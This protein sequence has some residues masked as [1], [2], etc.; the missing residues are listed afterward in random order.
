MD[1]KMLRAGVVK[2]IGDIESYPDRKQM[3]H[4]RDFLTSMSGGNVNVINGV[5]N[6]KESSGDRD[7][8]PVSG[9]KKE[10]KRKGDGDAVAT[11][12]VPG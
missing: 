12:D 2:A 4:F 6:G 8:K 9:G 5:L 1:I 7:A 3:E 10:R 11:D